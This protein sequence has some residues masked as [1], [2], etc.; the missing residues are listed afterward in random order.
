ME[1]FLSRPI[2]FRDGDEKN[3]DLTQE[4]AAVFNHPL[5]LRMIW[6]LQIALMAYVWPSG[7][8]TRRSHMIGVL[9]LAQRMFEAL[10]QTSSSITADLHGPTTAPGQAI[11]FHELPHNTLLLIQRILRLAALVHDLGH[12]PT[13]HAFD[14]IAPL[15][16]KIVALLDD[17]R[18]APVRPWLERL[19]IESP[20]AKIEHE[21]MSCLL[22]SVIAHDIGCEPWVASAVAVVLLGG[23]VPNSIPEDL[24]PFLPFIRDAVS[25]APFDADRGDYMK[26]DRRNAGAVVGDYDLEQLLR[27]IVCVREQDVYRLGWREQGMSAIVKALEARAELFGYIYHHDKLRACRL[28][29]MAM[30]QAAQVAQLEVI[31]TTSLDTV[32]KSYRD[33]GDHSFLLLMAGRSR[34]DFPAAAPVEVLANQLLDQRLWYCVHADIRISPEQVDDLA[35]DMEKEFPHRIFK[36]DKAKV[37]GAKDM[38]RAAHLVRLSANGYVS[39][40]SGEVWF[41]ESPDMCRLRDWPPVTRIYIVDDGSDNDVTKRLLRDAFVRCREARRS[42]V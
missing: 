13:S 8:H 5:M 7:T 40:G 35:A 28:M 34:P 21:V 6:V 32:L 38:S 22:F 39:V 33:L 3:T 20:D 27:F 15:V 9:R 23:P 25:S 42:A 14:G 30:A 4:E 12:G 16:R 19:K 11:R 2:T 36:V 29:L 17:P 31:D 37:A 41:S 26:R 1:N 10:I 24:R 18:L